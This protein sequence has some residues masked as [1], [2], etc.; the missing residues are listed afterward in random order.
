MTWASSLLKKQWKQN[1]FGN[2]RVEEGGKSFASQGERECYR[3]LLNLQDL[4][5]IEDVRLQDSVT[6]TRAK[7]RMIPDF[8]AYEKKL[9][10]RVYYEFKGHETDVYKIKLK[11]WRHYGPGILYVYKQNS[12]GLYLYETINPKQSTIDCSED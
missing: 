2:K 3:Y 11:L 10:Q 7:I 12:K 4:G 8:S 5:E 9:G 1:K 6:L